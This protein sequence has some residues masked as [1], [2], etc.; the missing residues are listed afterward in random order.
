MNLKVSIVA[1]AVLSLTVTAADAKKHRK[2]IRPAPPPAAAA[3][4]LWGLF[5]ND[6]GPAHF[7]RLPN[8]Q[9]VSSYECFTDEGYGRYLPCGA[10]EKQ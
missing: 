8:G 2:H 7:V 6:S 9:I 10:G 1:L 4:P 3:P 5:G